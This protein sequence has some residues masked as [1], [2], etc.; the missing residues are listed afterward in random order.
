FEPSLWR[1][2][3]PLPGNGI[4]RAEK[5]ASMRPLN[6]RSAVS[7]IKRS[8]KKPA[9]SGSFSSVS[10]N[11]RNRRNA[12]WGWKDSNL[13]PGRYERTFF[14]CA[15]TE[16]SRLRAERTPTCQVC[17]SVDRVT[18]A[19]RYGVPKGAPRMSRNVVPGLNI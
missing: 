13:Q 14:G 4:S 12:W 7:E 6:H 2:R 5:K 17:S 15:K 8:Y 9:N 16:F 10:G 19:F 11:L 18:G 3:S 1:M